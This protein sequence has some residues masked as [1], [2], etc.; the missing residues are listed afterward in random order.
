M[1][2]TIGDILGGVCVV[3]LP[4]LLIIVLHGAGVGQ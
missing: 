2:P 1:K 3:A 4:F